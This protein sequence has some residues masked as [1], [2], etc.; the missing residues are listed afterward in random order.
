MR[1]FSIEYICMAIAIVLRV[2]STFS[3]P[4]GIYKLLQLVQVYKS[5]THSDADTVFVVSYIETGGQ[6]SD[7]R[8][9]LWIA[10]LFVGPLIGSISSQLFL[11]I[12][13][14]IS[15]VS[16]YTCA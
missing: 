10:W 8:P 9:W 11:Y 13:V 14:Y 5:Y 4:I 2:I 3:G 16:C 7:I 15:V 6:D 12:S 1:T